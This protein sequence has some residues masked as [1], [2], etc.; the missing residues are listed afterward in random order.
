MLFPCPPILAALLLKGIFTATSEEPGEMLY[1]YV[2]GCRIPPVIF[3]YQAYSLTFFCVKE[4]NLRNILKR[5]GNLFYLKAVIWKGGIFA[6]GELGNLS[7]NSLNVYISHFS[8]WMFN[9][10]I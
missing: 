7:K 4:K 2:A 10:G 9:S 6:F 8:I 1:Y 5:Q 3:F